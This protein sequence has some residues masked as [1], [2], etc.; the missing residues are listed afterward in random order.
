MKK[1]KH[2][3]KGRKL[4]GEGKGIDEIYGNGRVQESEIARTSE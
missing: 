4:D 3:N 1:E 2:K